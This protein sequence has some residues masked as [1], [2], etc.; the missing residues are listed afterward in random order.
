MGGFVQ[1]R[2]VECIE[3]TKN[4]IRGFFHVCLTFSDLFIQETRMDFSCLTPP[5]IKVISYRKKKLRNNLLQQVWLTFVSF[6][7]F[8][9]LVE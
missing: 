9:S 6:V 2:I 3:L 5:L 8:E 1:V 4:L 7:S